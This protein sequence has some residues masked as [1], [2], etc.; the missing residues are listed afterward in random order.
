VFGVENNGSAGK[1]RG[2][3]LAVDFFFAPG[4]SGRPA[5]GTGLQPKGYIQG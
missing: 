1:A 2:E 4:F 3:V 5:A